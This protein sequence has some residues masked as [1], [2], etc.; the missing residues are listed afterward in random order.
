ME[1]KIT[2]R[3][4]DD[5]HFHPRTDE[6]LAEVLPVTAY[7][8]GRGIVMPN[9]LRGIFNDND[10][11]WYHDQIERVLDRMPIRP[12]FKPLMTI[13]ITDNTTPKMIAN[14]KRVGVVAGKVYPRG[15][16]TNSNEGLCDF[17]SPK[18]TETFRAMQSVGMLLLLHGELD[19][20][21][22]L[23][24][25]REEV[26]LSTLLRLVEN[27]PDLK[28]VLEHISTAIAVRI[29]EQLSSNV[30][31]TITAHH[32]WITL[33]DCIGYGI[34]PHNIC[35]PIPKGFDDRDALIK[36]ATSG[37]PKFF[38]GSDSAP[39]KRE[40]KECARGACGVYSAPILPQLLVDIFEKAERLHRLENFTSK[41]GADFYRL[42]LN[43]GNITLIK[44]EWQVPNQIG[45]V[46]P[47]LA[48][49]CL[50]WQLV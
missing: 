48:G 18:I 37:N 17:W 19:L 12:D 34:R 20:E 9:T 49:Q 14:A 30:A 11:M 13:Q 26:F 39:H 10:V 24:T 45:S 41:F 21:R 35:Y 8:S 29:I 46:V 43:E 25:K 4:F 32:L 44:K 27:F 42:P 3:R 5:M 23:V 16:T 22:T 47:F 38:L 7:Y 2:L 33:N 40:N 31:A 50:K 1:N 36:A 15:V 6:L 28:I